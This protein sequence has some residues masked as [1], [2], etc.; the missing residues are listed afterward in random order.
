MQT[1]GMLGLFSGLPRFEIYHVGV[2]GFRGFGG[3]RV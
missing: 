3:L 1:Y 2:M